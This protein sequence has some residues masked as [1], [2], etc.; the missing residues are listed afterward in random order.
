MIRLVTVIGHGIDLLPHFIEHYKNIVDEIHIGVYVSAVAPRIEKQ[1]RKTVE[2]YPNIK[3][4]EVVRDREFDW[5]RVTGLYNFIKQTHP[6]D[7]WVVADIDELH[8]YP[9]NDLR[10][11]VS[12]CNENGWVMARGGFIDRIGKGG[13]FPEITKGDDIFE[14]FPMAGFFRYPLS[15]A[16]PNKVC[17]MKG[18]VELTSGQH[19]AKLL[20]HTTWRWQGWNHPLIAPVETHSVQV[21]HFK[22]DKSCIERIKAVSDVKQDY[23]YSAEYKDMYNALRKTKFKINVKKPEFMFEDTDGSKDYDA[24]KQWLPLIRKIASI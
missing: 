10:Q 4:V 12:D 17:V 21:H 1:V 16:C 13:E 6:K 18:D 9:N 8:T 24:Y 5:A 3:V 19:Y 14:T 22:W 23:A 20:G 2:K 15:N 11:L 7:W